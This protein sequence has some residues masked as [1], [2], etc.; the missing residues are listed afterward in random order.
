M[1]VIILHEFF[2]LNDIFY[3]WCDAWHILIG[4]FPCFN[5]SNSMFAR[6]GFPAKHGGRWP[7]HC[8]WRMAAEM[9]GLHN[10]G[11]NFYF[12]NGM[13]LQ[14]RNEMMIPQRKRAD[15]QL[16]W[17]VPFQCNN[18]WGISEQPRIQWV[19]ASNLRIIGDWLL[20]EGRAVLSG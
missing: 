6:S 17:H 14:Q 20:E 1:W 16:E 3:K 7:W 5:N 19:L 8:G 15:W 4:F 10:L 11:K 13:Q 9:N 12:W 2:W 18:G